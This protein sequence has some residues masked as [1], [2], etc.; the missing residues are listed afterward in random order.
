MNIKSNKKIMVHAY[1]RNGWLYRAWEFPE[2]LDSNKNFTVVSL[3]NSKVI[4]NEKFS[5][6]NFI[7][8]NIKNSFWFFFP[9]KWYNIIATL[10][11]NNVIAY[12][13]NIASPF[14]YEEEAIKYF[15]FDLDIKMRNTS[16]EIYKILDIDEY[17]SNRRDYRY[18]KEV[19]DNCE[20]TLEL[21]QSEEF[22]KAIFKFI[23]PE[24]LRLLAKKRK[25]TSHNE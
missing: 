20:K 16:S 6:R 1:K 7:S 11:S 9:N 4:T 14:I 12:Y 22:R 23:S 8:K 18:E 3:V 17:E 10:T 2:V 21:F 24:L 19:I 25:V 5:P 13:V 15:D